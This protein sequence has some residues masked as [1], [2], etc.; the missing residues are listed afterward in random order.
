MARRGETRHPPR[1]RSKRGAPRITG[2]ATP[3]GKVLTRWAD[4]P[5][6]QLRALH[7]LN[8]DRTLA[9]RGRDALHRAGTGIADPQGRHEGPVA[10]RL[11]R[12][13]SASPRR[14]FS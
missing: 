5:P 6:P 13:R 1:R 10:P 9:D 3:A 7:P 12:A 8:A 14:R 2:R 11:H 4:N